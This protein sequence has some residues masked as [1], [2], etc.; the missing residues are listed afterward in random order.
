M[1]PPKS[2]LSGHSKKAQYSVFTGYVMAGIGALIGAGLL[3]I[4]LSQP[5]AFSVLRGGASDV[6]EPAGEATA[7]VRSGNASFW[8][9]VKAYV[10]AGSQNAALR[11]EV[12]LA[13]R[14]SEV[15]KFLAIHPLGG[16]ALLIG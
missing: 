3:A 6:V 4:S 13:A 7:I 10:Q 9:Q 8:E 12:E 11:E 14:R 16:P 2:R 15:E 1:A 5:T